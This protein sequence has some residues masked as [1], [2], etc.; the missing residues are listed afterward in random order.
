MTAKGYLNCHVKQ[1]KNKK[2]A[3]Y[4]IRKSIRIEGKVTKKPIK[5]FTYEKATPEEKEMILSYVERRFDF[6]TITDLEK[7][8]Q[9]IDIY[10]SISFVQNDP[11]N[12]R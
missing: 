4:S 7:Q 5:H 10:L 2:K 3:Y 1:L 6:S 11:L 8:Q 9:I 12:P